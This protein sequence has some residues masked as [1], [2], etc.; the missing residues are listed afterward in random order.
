MTEK[1]IGIG[2]AGS[3]GPTMEWSV[4]RWARGRSGTGVADRDRIG[5]RAGKLGRDEAL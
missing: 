3:R 5:A 2:G 4:E 1:E